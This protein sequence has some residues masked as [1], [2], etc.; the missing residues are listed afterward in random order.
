MPRPKKD[1]RFINYFIDRT[2]YDRLKVYAE[3]KGQSMTT[4]LERILSAHLDRYEQ[5]KPA[6]AD[7]TLYCE[8][9]NL[10]TTANRCPACGSRELR[11]PLPGDYCFL[12]EKEPLWSNALEELLRDNGIPCITKNALGAG[13]TS[14]IGSLQERTRFYVSYLKLNT[15]KALEEEF[16]SAKFEGELE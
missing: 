5:T 13:L 4:A 14:K 10:L 1:G 7:E 15:A 6:P 11:V 2:I 16:F 3:D 8:T 9:C 12:T